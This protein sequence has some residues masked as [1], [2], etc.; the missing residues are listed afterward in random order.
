MLTVTS[1]DFFSVFLQFYLLEYFSLYLN[2]AKG[3]LTLCFKR[4]ISLSGLS[5]CLFHLFLP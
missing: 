4:Q 3:L 5:Q 2:L 1:K